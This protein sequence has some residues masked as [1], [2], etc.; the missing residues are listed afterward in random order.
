M[1]QI[2]SGGARTSRHPGHFQVSTVVRQVISCELCEG[3]KVKPLVAGIE[4]DFALVCPAT[5]Y[6]D[7]DEKEA[8]TTTVAYY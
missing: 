2:I 4:V 6:T 1:N 3:S 7:E 5:R 8:Q